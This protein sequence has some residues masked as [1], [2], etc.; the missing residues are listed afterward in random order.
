M[1]RTLLPL[2]AGLGLALTAS[3]QE[4]KNAPP[5]VPPTPTL[6]PD[7]VTNVLKQLDEL[8]KSILSQRGTTLSTIIQKLH[9]AAQSDTSAINFVAEC[10]KLVNVKL[11]NADRREAQRI[12]QRKEAEKRE[13]KAGV[14]ADREGDY[15]AALRVCLEYI[16]LSLEAR[17][18]KDMGAFAS[19]ITAYHQALLS[20]GKK[21]KGRA[22]ELIMQPIIGGGGGRR[23]AGQLQLPEL[24]VVID[25]Y[26]LDQYL[27]RND[28]PLVPGDI[29]AMYDKVIVQAAR[30]KKKEDIGSLW[31]TGIN[32]EAS[33]RGLRLA[34]GEFKQWQASTYPNL[35]WHR[36]ED[37][38]QNGPNPVTGMA[39]MLKV[40]KDYPN[41]PNSPDWV[42]Q[43]RNMVSPP[44]APTPKA[45]DDGD[46]ATDAAAQ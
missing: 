22:G 19:K 29:A 39:E 1:H 30:E 28:W 5:Y 37:L 44:T 24:R 13:P 20:Y 16:A 38:A 21:L 34:E 10:D 17:D 4:N 25:A 11:K 32:T 18:V 36:A 41:H 9:S 31:E 23:T 2:V 43:L 14:D 7:Q 33:F 12:D 6:T 46:K 8:E 40:I 26:Q 15:G 27:H 3:A 45:P 35:R 42:R